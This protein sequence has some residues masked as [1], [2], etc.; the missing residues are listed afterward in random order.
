MKI[1]SEEDLLNLDVRKKIIEDILGSEN[2]NRK[3]GELRRHEV[4]RDKIKKWVLHSLLNEGFKPETIAQMENRAS[5]I[6]ICRKIVNKLAQTYIGGVERKVDDASSQLSIDALADELDVNTALKKSDR[7]RQLFKNTSVQVVARRCMEPLEDGYEEK[8]TIALKVLAPW[9][10]DVVQDYYNPE[11][12]MAFIL[13]DFPERHNFVIDSIDGS[14]GYR[15]GMEFD[16]NRGDR[17]EQSIAD[18]PS[19]TGIE[20]RT[21]IFWSNKYH[22]T[23]DLGGQ[24]LQMVEDNQNLNPIGILPFVDIHMDQDG[25]YWAQGGEDLI[26]GSI[27]VNKELTDL[28]F[29][30]FHQGFGQLVISGKDLPKKIE[31]GPNNAML[32]D[33]REGDPTPQV[34]YATSNPP[35]ESWLNKIKSQLAMLLSTN[36]LAPR[37]ISASLDASNVESGISKLIENSEVTAS[38]QDVQNIYQDAEPYMWEVIRRWHSLYAESSLLKEDLQLIPVF[39]DSNVKVKFIQTKPIVSEKENLEVLKLRKELGLDTLAGII[40]KDNPDLSKE[41]AEQKAKEVQEEKAANVESFMGDSGDKE[42]DSDEEKDAKGDKKVKSKP[43][44]E[45]EDEDA[46]DGKV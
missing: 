31:G 19:D 1:R 12:A 13:T 20:K 28:N 7:Y 29:V 26:D 3:M 44:I 21:F 32:F 42:K 4:Y 11:K 39:T 18:D 9:E 33:V 34:F 5:N 30:T 43:E 35:V 10:Y 2:E 17:K 46:E 22:F 36:D 15:S 6:S 23:C 41:E 8:Y 16:M 38:H 25:E 27:L 37:L 45:D 40:L 24:I 14:Q